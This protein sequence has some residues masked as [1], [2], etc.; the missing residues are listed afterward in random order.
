MK[1]IYK[2][3]KTHLTLSVE[4]SILIAFRSK[5]PDVNISKMLESYMDKAI[6]EKE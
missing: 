1:L 2:N 6:Y 5:Y 4:P 3:T